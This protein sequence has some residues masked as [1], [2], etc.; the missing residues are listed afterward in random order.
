MLH[1]VCN[2]FSHEI[3]I[4]IFLKAKIAPQ[5]LQDRLTYFIVY[6]IAVNCPLLRKVWGLKLLTSVPCFFFL[7]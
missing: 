7:P 5:I 2:S 6:F 4:R 3:P 1:S